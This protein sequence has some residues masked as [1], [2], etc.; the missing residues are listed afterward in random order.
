[1]A[2]LDCIFGNGLGARRLKQL[3]LFADLPRTRRRKM[4]RLTDTQANML[5]GFLIDE[6]TQWNHN[7]RR[8]LRMLLRDGLIEIISYGPASYRVTERGV[9]LRSLWL[10]KRRR[11]LEH[12]C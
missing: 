4:W 5:S 9:A 1:M 10:E 8:T 12:G 11:A 7:N 6:P 2:H 3:M